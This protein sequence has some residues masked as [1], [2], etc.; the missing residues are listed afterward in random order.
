MGSFS[1]R[2][3]VSTGR[4]RCGK[5]SSPSFAITRSPYFVIPA[6]YVLPLGEQVWIKGINVEGQH[7][8][9]RHE[10]G[11]FRRIPD[12]KPFLGCLEGTSADKM[13]AKE[14]PIVST[15]VASYGAGIGKSRVHSICACSLVPGLQS[16]VPHA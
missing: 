16:Q 8:V 1:Y 15:T 7:T 6:G 12:A 11:Q 2:L 5:S 10:Y 14:F 3:G 13:G 4:Y 9:V